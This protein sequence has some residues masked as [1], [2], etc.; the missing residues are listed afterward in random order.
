MHKSQP[1]PTQLNPI[2]A[3]PRSSAS[4]LRLEIRQRGLGVGEFSL[5][6]YEIDQM[7]AWEK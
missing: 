3:T 1:N 5:D 7:V 6:A 2:Q 4:G